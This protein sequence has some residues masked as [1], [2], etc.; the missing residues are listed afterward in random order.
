MK[1][2][3]YTT[4]IV[5][6]LLYAFAN[7]ALYIG[8]ICAFTNVCTI[9]DKLFHYLDYTFDCLYTL[10]YIGSTIL[11]LLGW[12]NMKDLVCSDDHIIIDLKFIRV[13]IV[14]LTIYSIV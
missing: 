6:F 13:Y 8:F 12:R 4:G 9:S 1:M 10:S 2:I 5:W 3:L 7:F 11:L 14:V